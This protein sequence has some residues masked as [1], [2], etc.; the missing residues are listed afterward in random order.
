MPVK[1]QNVTISPSSGSLIAGVTGTNEVGFSYG[2]SS[3]WRHKQLPLTLLVSDHST[4]TETGILYDPAG[5]I[6][7]DNTVNKNLYVICGGEPTTTNTHMSISLPKG[8]RF[9]GY[10]IVLLNNIGKRSN[11]HNM[12][13]TAMSKTF[14]EMDKNFQT[15]L[16]SV[17][18][19]PAATDSKEYVIERTSKTE[20]DMTNNLY[21]Y[22]GHSTTGFYAATIKSIELYFTAESAFNVEGTPESPASI[23]SEG[24]NM[25][26]TPFNTGKLDLGLLTNNTKNN[27]TYFS[28]DYTAVRELT[29]ENYLYQKEA[30]TSDKK[31]PTTAGSGNIQTLQNGGNLYYALGNGTYYIETP[32]STTDQSGKSIPLGFRIT[33][34]TIK[35]HYG[36]KASASTISYDG[37][38]GT[39]TYSVSN[40]WFGTT[41]YYLQTNGS[42]DNASVTW[43][44]NKYGKLYSGNT[45]LYV[46]TTTYGGNTYYFLRGTTDASKASTFKLVN[47]QLMYGDKYIIC[48]NV[49]S[50][51][52]VV[53]KYYS[54]Y[55]T[56]WNV[57]SSSA[58]NPAYTP[59]D[60]KISLYGTNKENVEEMAN[61]SS[62]NKNATL[63]VSGL[64]NDA[65]K[66]TISG[67]ADGT[68][69]LITYSLNMEALNPFINT[70]DIVCKSPKANTPELVQQFTSNDFQV[71]G[72]E[73]IFYVPSDFV[74]DG[75]T[76]KFS[77]ENL[78]SKYMDATYGH[79]TTGNSRNYL[80]KS[81]YYNSYGDGKQYTA[82]GNEEASIKVKSEAC[83]D[84]EFKY[85][86]ASELSNTTEG[87]TE[88]SL[89][90]YPYSEALYTSQ[91]GTFTTDIE[92]AIDGEKK[93]YLFTGDETRYNIAPTTALEHRKYAY[94]LMDIQLTKK[95]YDAYADLKTL[96]TATCYDGDKEVP[97]YGAVFKA[98]ET[99]HPGESGYEIPSTQAYLTTDMMC[100]ALNSALKKVNAD[101]KQVLYLDL[102]NLYSVSIESKERMTEIKNL[103]NPN[104]LIFFPERTNYNEDNYVQKTQSGSYRACKNI[105]ITDKQPFFTPYKIT[106]P[107]ENYATYTR[108]I[109]VPMNG[110][111]ARASIILPFSL[112]LQDGIHTNVTS[113]ACTFKVSQM[114]TDNCMT[115][116]ENEAQTTTNYIGK[117]K[118]DAV[119]ASSTTPNMPYMV[120]VTNAPDDETVSFIAT[121]YGSDVAATC[122]SASDDAT[123]TMNN[124]YTFTGGTSTGTIGSD[125]Y[126]FTCQGSYS[127]KKYAK[128]GSYYYFANNRFLNSSNLSASRPYVYIYP[129]RAYYSTANNGGN[130][131]KL[132]AFTITYDEL[133]TTGISLVTNEANSNL[134]IQSIVGGLI[135][136]ANNDV[137]VKIFSTS[138]QQVFAKSLKNGQQTELSLTAGIY[139]VN[140][141]KVV[142]Y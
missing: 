124:D 137:N 123:C 62:S 40:G 106:V 117:A 136:K 34:A 58:Q 87:V 63:S 9:T 39:I 11:F 61:V 60:F 114:T 97:M 89:V 113:D 93:C 118:F 127:G 75:Q 17:V 112:E 66:F 104:V 68:K 50:Y 131:K 1:G 67:L 91:G 92:I 80:V 103:Y 51:A 115:L 12:Q 18:T 141:K 54:D 108:L 125:S 44:L 36:T 119:T 102:T 121:Q 33:G 24:V 53:S 13:L 83:G 72:G 76:C 19:M 111:V 77:F 69:A 29:A 132:S 71:A 78:T 49:R 23:I 81:D 10:K 14:A 45:Y 16:T 120:E 134:S 46:S 140:G 31:L 3:L 28:Y 116:D 84:K 88:A 79:G 25:V 133:T 107:A 21:F 57:I 43:Y 48:S 129:F 94:Y 35:G 38:I 5:D 82:T 32:T 20:T 22:F 126:T 52:Q 55:A 99:G 6:V 59:S 2:W 15:N 74:D 95:D 86:N 26:A 37:N 109:M 135:I 122:P 139:V 70:L 27:S 30:V 41:T 73:F 64:N 85:N 105:V 96:Y 4:L 65:V 110:K 101:K 42:W 90:E 142:V 8:F 7:L 130:A 128:S 56:T 138:G 98:Y 47:G 100:N